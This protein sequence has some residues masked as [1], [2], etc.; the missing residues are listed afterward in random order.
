SGLGQVFQYLLIA[1]KD[2]GYDSMTL[3]SLNDWIV[4][5]LV[6]PVDGVTDV[7]SFGGNVRQYQVNIEPSKLLSYELTQDDIVTALDNNNAN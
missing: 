2:S 4:K 7:L 5:L 6:M 1:D 3:R